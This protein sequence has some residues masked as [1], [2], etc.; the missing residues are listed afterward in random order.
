MKKKVYFE[1]LDALRFLCFLSVFLFHSFASDHEDITSNS[2]Y[3]FVKVD[4]F[5]NGNLGVNF[6]FVLSGF[7]IT[8]LLITE[9]RMNEQ[10]SLTKFWIR[11][12]LRIWP[13]FYACVLFGFFVFPL[14][15]TMFGEVPDESATMWTYMVFVNNFD[16]IYNGPPDASLLGVLWSVAIEEQFYLL[17]PI[18]LFILPVR[19]YWIAFTTVIIGSLAFRATHDTQMI[20]ELHTLSCIGDMA[21]GA[22]GAWLVL[23]SDWFKQRIVQLDRYRVTLLYVALIM[24]FL[25][26]DE[27]FFDS[28][29]LRVI[30]R[31]LI[32]LVM[33]MVILEQCF[34]KRSLIKLSRFKWMSQ[35]G[36]I[37]Y[38]LYCLHFVGILIA[39]TITA[40]LGWNTELWQVLVLETLL[41]LGI[42]IGLS[43]FS[44]RFYERPFLKLKERFSFIT[45]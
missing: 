3:R 14:L 35:L 27:F 41:A 28:Y 25:F 30:E 5:G 34:A 13:L 10:L 22:F 21:I 24:V 33:V 32:A 19:R 17:W 42:T 26:R 2:V 38:G 39:T 40:K 16:F 44:Y 45:K 18:V 36:V 11:R 37:S 8:Y 6:F 12:I 23:F 43:W 31:P 7:L 1:N 29:V 4:L 15:K 9:K 20:H